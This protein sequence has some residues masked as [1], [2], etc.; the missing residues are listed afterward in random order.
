MRLLKLILPS[1]AP[2]P[3]RSVL[4]PQ[5]SLT[6]CDPM[7]CSLPGSPLHR[8]SPGKNTGVSCH[9]LLQRVFLTQGSNLI[10]LHFW[11]FLYH[12]RNQGSPRSQKEPIF[13]QLHQPRI[14][15]M[16]AVS[17]SGEGTK[18]LL[19]LSTQ[20]TLGQNSETFDSKEWKL[21][22]RYPPT[23]SLYTFLSGRFI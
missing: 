9:S 6:L 21:T 20:H 7:D 11:Q 13:T 19:F 22:L 12:L 5:P 16:Q 2:K 10:L 14:N 23:K 3:Q 15:V 1:V 17:K 4:V 18:E 8:I